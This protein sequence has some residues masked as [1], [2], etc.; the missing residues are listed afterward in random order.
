MFFP[1]LLLKIEKFIVSDKWRKRL[2]IIFYELLLLRSLVSFSVR[3]TDITQEKINEMKNCAA[4]L[5][6]LCCLY[7]NIT[8][9]LWTFLIVAPV[10]SQQMF[11][12][13]GL[14][15][16]ANSMEGREQ[17]HQVIKKYMKNTTVQQRW[18]YVFRHEFISTVYLREN[19]FDDLGYCKKTISYHPIV[20][21]NH[22]RCGLLLNENLC[23]IC[24]GRE[25]MEL[26]HNLEI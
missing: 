22:C 14:G 6:H 8:P 12:N 23:E 10:H 16:G 7:E 4:K 21:N 18:E 25:F 2:V 15:L 19:G 11:T 26:L 3:V 9:S 17:K 1:Q 24:D 20:T 13:L 5:Y